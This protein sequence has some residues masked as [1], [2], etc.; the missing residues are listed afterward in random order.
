MSVN[1]NILLAYGFIIDSDDKTFV[2]NL[3]SKFPHLEGKSFKSICD[4]FN[5]F[6][7]ESAS[8]YAEDIMQG[9]RHLEV[10]GVAKESYSEKLDKLVVVARASVDELWNKYNERSTD[11]AF[12]T[13]QG[14]VPDAVAKDFSDFQAEFGLESKTAGPVIWYEYS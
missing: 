1:T 10:R 4:D 5:R 9:Y 7:W 8:G 2:K 11:L 14:T 12:S 13:D 6:Y 3:V